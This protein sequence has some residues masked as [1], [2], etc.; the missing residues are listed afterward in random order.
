MLIG[1]CLIS[2][3][4]PE[5]HSL[6]EKRMVVKGILD[7]VQARHRLAVAEVGDQ[8]LWQRAQ[9][10]FA[11]IGNDQ[12][13]L[14]SALNAAVKTVESEPRAEVLDVEVEWR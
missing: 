6:K 10:A 12:A 7:R 1:A 5:A 14:D 9:I 3:F 8:E 2:L 4:I 13:I 11:A